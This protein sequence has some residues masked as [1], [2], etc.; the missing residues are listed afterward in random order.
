MVP[1][2]LNNIAEV[3]KAQ[4]RLP[5]AEER[6]LEALGLQEKR[7]G[8]D[9][10][11]VG[12]HSTIL[13]SSGA[14]KGGF[15]R[16]SSWRGVPWSSGKKHWGPIMPMSPPASI[17]LRLFSRDREELQKPKACL[18]AHLPSRKGLSG[19]ITRMSRLR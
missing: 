16:P 17:T 4:G 6:F 1:V 18:F 2:A 15:K 12:Q 13:E 7:H 19:R 8:H 14:C 11:Y 10:L 5:L 9:S 3:Y